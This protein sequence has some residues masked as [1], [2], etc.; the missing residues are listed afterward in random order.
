MSV[1]RRLLIAGVLWLLFAIVLGYAL[2][3]LF[4]AASGGSSAPP[5][6]SPAAVRRA[7][8]RPGPTSWASSP[9]RSS[10]CACGCETLDRAR[11]EFIANASHELRTPLFSLGGLPRAAGERGARRGDAADFLSD[12]G[13]GRPPDEA[14]DRP[15]RPVA[16]GRRAA[17]RRA[18]AGRPGRGRELWRPSSRAVAERRPRARPRRRRPPARW[19]TSSACSRSA[20][21][22]S[23]TRSCTRRRGRRCARASPT[24]ARDLEVEDDGPGIPPE[25]RRTSSSAS[26]GRGRR[27]SGSGLGLAIA[28]ELATLMDGRVGLEAGPAGR[29]AVHAAVPRRGRGGR[30]PS[31]S[32]F[33]RE[34]AAAATLRLLPSG[35]VRAIAVVALVSAARARPR[36]CSSAPAGWVGE[37]EG[38]RRSS[39]RRRRRDRRDRSRS[40]RWSETASIPRRSTRPLAGVVTISSFF[41]SG[42]RAQGSGFVVSEEGHVL[43]NSQ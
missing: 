21:P 16:P 10:A 7:G 26:T 42:R 9:R 36:S 24:A 38:A 1:E 25:H 14:R 11:R 15:A 2:A 22:W 23:R 30:A 27:A 40:R 39:S 34:N 28:R 31:A 5:R 37:A 13:A 43:T 20:A 8:G 17:A 33:P 6:G 29:S 12:A 32:S 41:S 35:W 3:T 19:A 18:R 4:A